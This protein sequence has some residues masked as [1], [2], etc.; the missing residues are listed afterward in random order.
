MRNIALG[1]SLLV[2]LSLI[3]FTAQA[4]PV[5]DE[6]SAVCYSYSSCDQ[7]CEF[8]DSFDPQT[9]NCEHWVYATCGEGTY[10][11]CG[12]CGIADTWEVEQEIS[13][14]HVGGYIC[15][16]EYEYYHYNLSVFIQNTKHMRRIT[17]GHRVC[18][19][20]ESTVV[21]SSY[22]FNDTCY[23]FVYPDCCDWIHDVYCNAPPWEGDVSFD[24]YMECH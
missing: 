17:Y 4:E 19:G 7:A 13:R 6:C 14:T 11:N 20:V 21:L 3:P 9:N 16:H 15:G 22:D 8:C 18:N 10:G 12:G 24:A 2:A 1:F 5:N 23:E